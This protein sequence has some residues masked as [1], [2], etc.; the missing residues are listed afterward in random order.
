MSAT[1][2]AFPGSGHASVP[3]GPYIVCLPRFLEGFGGRVAVDIHHPPLPTAER[4]SEAMAVSMPITQ[5]RSR[6]YRR[7]YEALVMLYDAH[8]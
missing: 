8:G 7:R 1:R 3:A 2:A 4:R 6:A 5:P